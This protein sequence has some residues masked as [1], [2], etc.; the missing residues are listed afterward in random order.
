M[1]K[2]VLFAGTT[3]GRRIAEGCRGKKIELT[4]SVATE[5]GEALLAPADNVRVVTGRKDAAGIEALLEGTGAEL[6]IDATHP[7]AEEVTRTLREVCSR[8]GTEYIRVLRDA[9]GADAEGCVFVNGTDGAVAYLNGTEGNVLLTVG[10]KELARY[11]EGVERKERLYARVLPLRESVEAALSLGIAGQRLICMQG[12]FTQEMNEATIRMLG[13]RYLVTKDTGAAGGFGEKVRAAKACGAV[14]VVI[15]RPAD[16]PG[17]SAEECLRLLA[18][19]SGE[20]AA[21]A[22]RITVLG[23]GPGGPGCLT[24]DAEKACREAELIV[25]AKRVT[26]ALE[27]FGKPVRNAVAAEEIER[28]LRESPCERIVAAMSG[29]TGFFSGAKGLLERIRDLAPEVLPGVS[30]VSV[31]AAKAGVPWDGALLLSAHGRDCNYVSGIRRSERTFVLTGGPRGVRDLVDALCEN[32]LG[33]VRLTVGE[34]LS[35]PGERVTRGTAEELRGKEFSS[36]AL[37]LAENPAAKDA[38]LTPGWPDESFERAGV[39]MTKSEVRSVVLGKLRLT[40]DAV[41]WDVGAGTGSVSLETAAVCE[42]GRVYAIERKE[43]ACELI[44][45]N[46]KRLGITNLEVVRGEA[47]ACLADLP[48]PTHVFIGGSGG[49]LREVMEAA[50]AG[51]PDVRIVLTAVTAETYA[52]A[53]EALKALPVTEEEICEV[54]V[55]RARRA[56]PYHLM[57]AQN[58]VYVVSCRGGR[59]DG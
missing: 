37:V 8:T 4:V 17:V 32:G 27:R 14:S 41:C 58:P 22:K 29:D 1:L 45:R 55:A 21:P 7:Y 25:G 13:I 19:R 9:D 44:G 52:A 20:G 34:E 51:N 26:D 2:A 43:D 30:S 54:S 56:G 50:L 28:I 15:R 6:V 59:T 33:G 18:E 36:T 35:L 47:P 3:E 31:F 40:R 46:K 42:R 11:A 5:Y 24:A 53:L 23:I 10:G 38:V 39:P 49:E 57:T 48:A 16:G 12:P